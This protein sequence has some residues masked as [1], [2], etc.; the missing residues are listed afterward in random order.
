VRAAALGEPVQFLLGPARA[1]T[2]PGRS[3]EQQF[4]RRLYKAL[5]FVDPVPELKSCPDT[6]PLSRPLIESLRAMTRGKAFV[7]STHSKARA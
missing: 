7:L 1:Q 5:I 2:P 4:V 6:K 3:S